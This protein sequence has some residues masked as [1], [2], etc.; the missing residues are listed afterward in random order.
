MGDRSGSAAFV[1]VLPGRAG[2]LVKGLRRR[3]PNDRRSPGVGGAAVCVVVHTVGAAG[4]PAVDAMNRRNV[5]P[6]ILAWL[7]LVG[8]IGG[9]LAAGTGR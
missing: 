3:W 5:D 7:T 9:V 2:Q 4:W 1:R 6:T 8:V